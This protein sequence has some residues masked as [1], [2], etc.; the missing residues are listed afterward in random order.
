MEGIAMVRAGIAPSTF[1]IAFGYGHRA[2]G[3]QD[4]TIDGELTSGNSAIGSGVHQEAMLDPTLEGVIYPLADN[5]A[6][7]P[8]RSGGMYKIEKA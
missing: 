5:D 7:T 3:A 1:G 8:G 2:Y 6:S 4:I